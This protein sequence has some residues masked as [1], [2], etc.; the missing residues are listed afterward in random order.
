VFLGR[1]AAGCFF[2]PSSTYELTD[3]CLVHH[4]RVEWNYWN[5]EKYFSLVIVRFGLL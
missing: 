2:P 1:E 5:I 3:S 4:L